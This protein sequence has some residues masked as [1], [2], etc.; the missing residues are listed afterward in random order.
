MTQ[1]LQL[2][3]ADARSDLER[4]SSLRSADLRAELS[5]SSRRSGQIP[6]SPDRVPNSPRGRLVQASQA[7]LTASDLTGSGTSHCKSDSQRK[8]QPG[9]IQPAK[10]L[11]D[12]HPRPKRPS[13]AS[14]AGQNR[15]S[16]WQ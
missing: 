2:S 11:I 5:G 3:V 1:R 10:P 14:A 15:P 7:P 13:F 8:R 9:Q 6:A 12:L 4:H 16:A